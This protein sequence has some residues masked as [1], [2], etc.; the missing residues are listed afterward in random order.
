MV[1]ISIFLLHY[2]RGRGI[3]YHS[4]W[5]LLGLKFFGRYYLAKLEDSF[6]FLN[7]VGELGFFKGG[8]IGV[9]WG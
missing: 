5:G 2:G 9:Y 1:P 8:N 3:S 6:S 4:K 7:P